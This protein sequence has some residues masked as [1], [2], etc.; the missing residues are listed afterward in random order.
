MPTSYSVMALVRG[1]IGGSCH[2]NT[3]FYQP[4]PYPN[5]G[6]LLMVTENRVRPWGQTEPS[7]TS[8]GIRVGNQGFHKLFA[9]QECQYWH[10]FSCIIRV[11]CEHTELTKMTILA[12]QALLREHTNQ[13]V[14]P[15][16]IELT[17]SAI[18]V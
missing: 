3:W 6:G 9:I 14:T 16:S 7:S 18:W 4:L 12:S 11:F 2:T 13:N 5:L 17:T 1:M 15:L 8:P 10:C